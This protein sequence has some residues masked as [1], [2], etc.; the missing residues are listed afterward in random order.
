MDG[1]KA[2]LLVATPELLDPNFHRAVV[3]VLERS[4]ANLLLEKA[5][6]TTAETP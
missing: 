4:E 2:R 3:L 6:Q 1:T 5:L